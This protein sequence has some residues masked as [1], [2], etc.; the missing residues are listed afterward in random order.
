MMT[1][2]SVFMFVVCVLLIWELKFS[3]RIIAKLWAYKK[4]HLSIKAF[5]KKAKTYHTDKIKNPDAEGKFWEIAECY[6]MKKEKKD[7]IRIKIREH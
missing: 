5:H 3:G 7:K 1:A 6:M 4:I 2:Q